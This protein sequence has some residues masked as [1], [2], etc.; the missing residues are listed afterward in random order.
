M[1]VL[2]FTLILLLKYT[3]VPEIKVVSLA[4]GGCGT[5]VWN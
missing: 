1:N 3:N 2:G 4:I 5:D